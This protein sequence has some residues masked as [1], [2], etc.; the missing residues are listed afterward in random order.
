MNSDKTINL[1]L[2]KLFTNYYNKEINKLATAIE[3]INSNLVQNNSILLSK[4]E[5]EASQI[6]NFI[7]RLNSL[8]SDLD[9]IQVFIRRFPL[10]EYHELNNINQLDFIKYH[11]EVFIY[12]IHTLLEVKKLWLND[13][14]KIELKERDYNWTKLKRFNQIQKSPAKAI[15]ESYYKSF[16]D[17]IDFR[18]LNTHRT[19][20]KDIKGGDFMVYDYL[21]KTEIEIKKDYQIKAYRKQKIEH[22]KNGTEIAKSYSNKFMNIILTD[23]FKDKKDGIQNLV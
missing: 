13:F 4:K 3:D 7:T 19:F 10:K 15:I 2:Q 23:F 12:K 1:E 11:Y 18:H 5:K 21:K 9:K 6:L 20:Y 17:I 22:I 16:E 8:A 14:Y